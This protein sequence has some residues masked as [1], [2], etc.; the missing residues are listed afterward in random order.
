[1]ANQTISLRLPD[2]LVK[3]LPTT[4]KRQSPSRTDFIVKA[5]REKLARD[6]TFS[7]PMVGPAGSQSD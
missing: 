4:D 1:M 5:I 3:R 2:D 7:L 6:K